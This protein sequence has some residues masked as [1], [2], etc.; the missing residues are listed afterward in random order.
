MATKGIKKCLD[1][2]QANTRLEAEV[3]GYPHSWSEPGEQNG[4]GGTH[5]PSIS[6]GVFTKARFYLLGR[7]Y[8]IKNYRKID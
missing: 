1:I 3:A 4:V 7:E 5:H 6:L 8:S 2:K